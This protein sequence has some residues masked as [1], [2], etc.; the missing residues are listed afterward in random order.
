MWRLTGVIALLMVGGGQTSTV[1]G[2]GDPAVTGSGF[3]RGGTGAAWAGRSGWVRGPAIG[4]WQV[5]RGSCVNGLF[6]SARE[7]TW[8]FWT[9]AWP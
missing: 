5:S 2:W 6:V 4:P 7:E 9:L 3:R 1:P 8:I